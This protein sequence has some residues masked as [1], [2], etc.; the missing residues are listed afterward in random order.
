LL[1][2]VPPEVVSASGAPCSA[3][4]TANALVRYFLSI[5][6]KS[7]LFDRLEPMDFCF[8]FLCFQK[9]FVIFVCSS[10]L[11]GLLVHRG[12]SEYERGSPL[13]STILRTECFPRPANG[14]ERQSLGFFNHHGCRQ[15]GIVFCRVSQYFLITLCRM[16]RRADFNVNFQLYPALR[17]RLFSAKRSAPGYFGGQKCRIFILMARGE[18]QRSFDRRES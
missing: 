2:N 7:A 6:H 1:L 13:G 9:R 3:G 17:A 16:K 4:C 11:P 5:M 18:P 15:R 12:F 8:Y 14:S 10:E